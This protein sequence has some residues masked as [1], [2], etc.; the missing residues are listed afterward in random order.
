MGGVNYYSETKGG[1]F[2]TRKVI[3]GCTQ[4]ATT[5]HMISQE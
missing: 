2:N 1:F 4:W 3:G 5:V